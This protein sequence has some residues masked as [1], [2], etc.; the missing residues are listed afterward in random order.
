MPIDRQRDERDRL[1]RVWSTVSAPLLFLVVAFLLVDTRFGI[2]AGAGAFVLLFL[3]VESIARHHFIAFALTAAAVVATVFVV[4]AVVQ[5][6]L[7]NWQLVLAA[8]LAALAA[9]VLVANLRDLR[10]S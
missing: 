8:V 2:V 1:L 5:G 3:T 4:F 9:A 7:G 6:L 10:R